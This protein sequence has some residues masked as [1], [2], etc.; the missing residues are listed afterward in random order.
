MFSLCLMTTIAWI[1]SK[2]K[3]R[4]TKLENPKNGAKK[5][6]T[7][8]TLP[9]LREA[10]EAVRAVVNENIDPQ[11]KEAISYGMLGW[12][13]PHDVYPAGYHCSPELPLPFASL[14]SQKNHMALYLFCVYCD[15]DTVEWLKT[16][17][18]AT[19]K[20]LDMGKSCLRFKKLEDVPLDVVA[21]VVRRMTVEHF[22]EAYEA[23]LAGTKSA[24]RPVRKKSASKRVAAKKS[25]ARKKTATR[26]ATSTG[27][28]ASKKKA[29]ATKSPARPK[30]AAAKQSPARKNAAA[31]KATSTA[32]KSATKKASKKAAPT[33][34][35]ARTKKAAAKKGAAR[36]KT[37]ARKADTSRKK[38]ARRKPAR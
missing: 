22:V 9:A 24:K 12:V 19:G 1:A 3:N 29:A 17:W 30:K 7:G 37:T 14:A 26:K 13:V 32:K 5:A 11:V 27:K 4:G 28:K 15:P 16:A 21:E 25:P 2:G 34:S 6:T 31:R 10:I 20:R 38:T 33:K 18:K 23:G 36:K 8:A 35:P